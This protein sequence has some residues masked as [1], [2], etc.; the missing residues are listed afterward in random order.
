VGGGPQEELRTLAAELGIEGQCRFLGHRRDIFDVI[1]A[2]DLLVHP[3]LHE[4]Q[5]QVL[6]EAMALGVPVIS[7]TVGAAEEMVIPGS[8]GWLVP[9]R[10][11]PALIRALGEAVSDRQ[12]LRA[13]GLAG[14]ELVR[15]LYPIERMTTGYEALYVEQLQGQRAEMGA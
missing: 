10:D 14:Q 5:C 9:P 1:A 2:S 4:A 8:N 13:Y 11:E 15:R 3:S 7:S 12:R 6:I